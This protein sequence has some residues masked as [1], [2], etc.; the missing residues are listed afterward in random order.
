M[1]VQRRCAQCGTWNKDQ[2]NCVSCG[3][4]L[5]PVI[6][7][8]KREEAREERRRNTPPTALDRFV[9]KWK[10]HPFFP[11][12]ALYYIVYTIGFI[13]FAIAS[14]FAWLAASPNG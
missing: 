8:K 11:I 10:N 12:K 4:L 14:F 7:E 9:V 13:F 3:H 2:E 1:A 6:I 5:D